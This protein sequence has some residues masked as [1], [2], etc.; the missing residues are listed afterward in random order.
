MAFPLCSTL[1]RVS[2][3]S[4]LPTPLGE[5]P[6]L[7]DKLGIR[8]LIKREDLTGLATGGNKIRN[9]EFVFGDLQAKGCDAV[10][11]TAGVQSNMCRSTAA[12]ASQTGIPCVLLLRGSGQE[13]IQGNLLLDHLLGADV[14]FIPTK[15]PYD[16]R[17]VG[18]LDDTKR[19][20]ES[21]GL[22][23]YVLHLTGV[24]SSVATCA[25]VD[26][27]EELA[28]QLGT[29]DASPDWLYVTVG[30][31][32]TMAGLS[33]GLR[34]LGLKTRVVGISANSS[35]DLLTPKIVDYA[36]SAAGQ[37]GLDTRITQDDF[38]LYDNFVGTAYGEVY[39]EAVD[40]IKRLAREEGLLLDPVYTGKCM[41]AL[42]DHVKTGVIR[43]GETV[44]FLHS[45]GAPNVFA[46]AAELV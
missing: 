27:A 6:A 34:H 16:E 25:Y 22:T 36:N 15:D 41:T 46:Q 3:C 18:W 38:D 1:R 40:T 24:T 26:G 31:G 37:I 23:P 5:T 17:I 4:A 29:A 12:A 14:R 35:V 45:G 32:I 2:L 43:P 44:V 33:I 21:R 28:D 42:L 9:L 10:I 13:E 39:P 19:E 30:A 8:I 7:S 20:L 11:A